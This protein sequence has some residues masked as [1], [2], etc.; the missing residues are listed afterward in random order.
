MAKPKK[1]VAAK[2]LEG[3]SE[4]QQRQVE[5]NTGKLSELNEQIESL[6][7]RKL[8]TKS[9]GGGGGASSSSAARAP[10][11]AQDEFE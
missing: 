3:L 8:S 4:G 10:N 11:A 5:R 7:E 9:G 1:S 2:E 6:K